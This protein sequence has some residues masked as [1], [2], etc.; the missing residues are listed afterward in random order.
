MILD[1]YT[2]ARSENIPNSKLLLNKDLKQ[3][4]IQI[5]SIAVDEND[6]E[7]NFVE[8][9]STDVI[10]KKWS[11]FDYIDFKS[12]STLAEMY[13]IYKALTEIVWFD[14]SVKKVNIYTD[15]EQSYNF[16]NK[17]SK[18]PTGNVG[19]RP[20]IPKN[21]LMYNVYSDIL[22]KIEFLR[23][24]NIIVDVRWIKGHDACYFNVK[25]DLLCKRVDTRIF[26]T[27]TT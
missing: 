26:S 17:I 1:I 12:D 13:S 16:I 11:E 6:I 23:N 2:D 10:K 9:T 4:G 3:I 8:V 15:S 14:F 20:L 5:S 19:F 7:Y 22:E 18:D 21:K 25:A 24:N 27:F